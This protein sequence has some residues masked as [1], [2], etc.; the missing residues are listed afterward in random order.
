METTAQFSYA[1]ICL[2]Q[3]NSQMAIYQQIQQF[4]NDGQPTIQDLQ[5][6]TLVEEIP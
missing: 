4:G 3:Q 5:Q 6:Q 1:D 2:M